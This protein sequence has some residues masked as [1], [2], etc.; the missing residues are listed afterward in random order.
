[1]KELSVTTRRVIAGITL[2]IALPLAANYYLDWNWFAE[3]GKRAMMLGL[4][5]MTLSHIFFGL[6]P[7]EI[8]KYEKSKR[9]KSR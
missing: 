4:V 5:V 6:S 7:E 8:R 3:F 9:G 2:I 1:M